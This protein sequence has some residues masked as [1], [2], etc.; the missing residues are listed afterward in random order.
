MVSDVYIKVDRAVIRAVN[1]RQDPG[2]SD[3]LRLN[4]IYKKIINSPSGVAL[5]CLEPVRPPG[6]LLFVGVQMAVCVDETRIKEL[7]ELFPLLRRVPGAALIRFRILQ[8]QRRRRDVE[9]AADDDRFSF[10]SRYT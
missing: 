4:A 7:L 6:I 3:A 10:C 8:I 2:V 9:I 5:P 1:V